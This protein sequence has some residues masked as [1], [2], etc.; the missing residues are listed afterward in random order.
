MEWEVGEDLA[1][2][3]SQAGCW[4]PCLSPVGTGQGWRGSLLTV[5]VS[6]QWGRGKKKHSLRYWELWF[7]HSQINLPPA[8]S[9]HRPGCVFFLRGLH[10][11]GRAP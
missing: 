1:A 4:R 3:Q 6:G 9:P 11:V 8:P 7:N 10:D 5:L 2:G